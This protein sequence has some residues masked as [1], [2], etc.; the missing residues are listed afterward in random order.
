MKTLG[1]VKNRD[2]KTTESQPLV[3]YVEDNL[4]NQRVASLAL[5]KKYDL[6]I[7]ANSRD[8]CEFIQKSGDRISII[9]MDIELQD[10]DLN[11]I[12]LTRLLRGTLNHPSLPEYAK[13]IARLDV[14]I[15]F[16]TAFGDKYST[17]SLLEAGGNRVIA[18]PV[19]F[20]ELQLAMTQIRLAAVK[21]SP[22][23]LSL[24]K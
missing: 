1:Y 14:P 10:S 23:P 12:E 9:L 8:V 7:L 19:D 22:L 4:E 2:R 6:Q 17:A 21:Q 5:R 24:P 3:L 16:V 18:K 13:A 20:V 15:L 11:G